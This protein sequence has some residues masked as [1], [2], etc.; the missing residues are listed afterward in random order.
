MR[1]LRFLQMLVMLALMIAP[2]GMIGSHAAMAMPHQAAA[3][4]EG[5]NS[6]RSAPEDEQRQSM[7]DCAIACSAMPATADATRPQR[8][9]ISP[10]YRLATILDIEG[11]RPEAATPPPDAPEV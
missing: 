10:E 4:M 11:M 6:Q 2:A 8:L 1:C 5:C 3:P 9:L 7:I